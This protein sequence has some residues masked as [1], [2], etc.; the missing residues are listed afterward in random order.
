MIFP[1]EP[2]SP[3]IPKIDA[4]DRNSATIS[5]SPPENDGGSPVTGY[6]VEYR[7]PD[8]KNW[9][10]ASTYPTKDTSY[11]V[12]NLT[13]G[14]EYQ[15]RVIAV[16]EAGPGKPSR[17]SDSIIA[18]TPICELPQPKILPSFTIPANRSDLIGIVA[19]FKFTDR[20]N[21]ER[22]DFQQNRKNN[23]KT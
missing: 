8:S 4:V 12:P 6:A 16:N 7:R 19:I 3:S 20:K 1:D 2:D 9:E 5:W 10:P 21:S 11:T 22:S 23:K 15:F 13:E 18:K 14:N 17:A